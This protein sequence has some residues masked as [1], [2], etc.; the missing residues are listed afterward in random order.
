MLMDDDVSIAARACQSTKRFSDQYLKAAESLVPSIILSCQSFEDSSA[1][2][3]L[4]R[5]LA[6][7]DIAMMVWS[8]GKLC[9]RSLIPSFSMGRSN[10][11]VLVRRFGLSLVRHMRR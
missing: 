8:F 7:S 4:Y 11:V 9:H 2:N 1:A 3:H 5:L 6:L 10:P